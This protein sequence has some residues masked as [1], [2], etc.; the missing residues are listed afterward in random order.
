M[1]WS[2]VL[3]NRLLSSPLPETNIKYFKLKD[4]L[5]RYATEISPAHKGGESEIYRLSAISRCWL[6]DVEVIDLTKYHFIQFREDRLKKVSSGT[7]KIEL[8]LIKRV[9]KV[10]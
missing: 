10:S 7:A 1:R 9:L 8:M 2:K 6:G 5:Q 4:L 3:E